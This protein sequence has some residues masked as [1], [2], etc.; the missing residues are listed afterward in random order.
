MCCIGEVR[1][2]QIVVFLAA[3]LQRHIKKLAF[4]LPIDYTN[5]KHRFS[6]DHVDIGILPMN[7]KN[8][9]EGLLGELSSPNFNK[10]KTCRYF[11]PPIGLA[12]Q[13]CGSNHSA[14][15]GQRGRTS[16]AKTPVRFC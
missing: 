10:L 15:G 9:K 8:S 6:N 4:P 2:Q 5:D 7:S 12:R 14:C 13:A 1:L 11:R 16:K 3:Y